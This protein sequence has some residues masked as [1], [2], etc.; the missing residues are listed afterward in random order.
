MRGREHLVGFFDFI[1]GQGV[2]GLAIGLVVGAAAST[3]VN[4]LVNNVVMPPLGFL[5]G[6]ADGL[7]GLVLDMGT[8]AAGEPAV[9]RYGAFLSDLINFIV[10]AV[11][12]YLVVKLLHIDPPMKTSP[13]KNKEKK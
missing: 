11:V 6:S 10:I 13:V 1:R 9:L 4:S 5:L 2:I 12:V 3:L 7:R 8:T